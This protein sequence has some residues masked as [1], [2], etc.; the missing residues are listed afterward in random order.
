MLAAELS[1]SGKQG[2]DKPD[3][4]FKDRASAEAFLMEFLP[5]EQVLAMPEKQV[6]A[7]AGQYERQSVMS[8]TGGAYFQ[9]DVLQ[10][11][12]PLDLTESF[13]DLKN[14]S[15]D[16]K[17]RIIT[18]RLRELIG[19]EID[20]QDNRII[21]IK[22]PEATHIADKTKNKQRIQKKRAITAL[23]ELENV[24]KNSLLVDEADVDITHNRNAERISY[25]LENVDRFLTFEA[26]VRISDDI[27][28]VDLATDKLKND[29]NPRRSYLYDVSIRKAPYRK[30]IPRGLSDVNIPENGPIVNQKRKAA[31]IPALRAIMLGK[32]VTIDSFNHELQHDW[33]R[34]NFKW[35]RSGQASEAFKYYWGRLEQYVGISPDQGILAS[36]QNESI[37]RLFEAYAWAKR[38]KS[39]DMRGNVL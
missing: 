16:E 33:T 12:E 4:E 37:S 13:T 29:G 23:Q 31:Y 11:N 39:F 19:A 5:E 27:F 30:V 34:N 26:P 6:M 36:E 3:G 25:K 28:Y 17:S 2:I 32:D 20:T 9:A 7:K 8:E 15:A 22:E 35:M 10:E 24:I 21:G 18:E 14:K 1:S 38:M